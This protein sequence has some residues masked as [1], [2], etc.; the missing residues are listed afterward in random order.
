MFEDYIQDA[1]S[2]YELAETKATSGMEREAKMFYRASVFCAASSLEA[3]I[4]FIG[5]TF[6][7]GNNLDKN[8][9]AFLNDKIL[10]VSVTKATIEEKV[11]FNSIDG[12]IKFIIT[13]FNVPINIAT[14]K[15]W[16]DFLKF[17]DLRDS[18]IH[19]KAISDEKTLSE[20]KQNIK[21]GLNANIDIMS[22]ISQKLFN[23]PLRKSLTDLKI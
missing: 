23:K 13:K 5:E 9:I 11:K 17:K 15:Q 3:F 14:A 7:Q 2:F 22:E 21:D 12:K 10:V 6:K 19:S 20:Y 8:E 1:Y 16:S 4:K 18:L